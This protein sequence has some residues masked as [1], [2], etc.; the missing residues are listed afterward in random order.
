[1]QIAAMLRVKNEARWIGEVIDALKPACSPIFVMDDHSDDDTPRIC[2]A[3]GARVAASPYEGINE[4]RDKDWLLRGVE[5]EMKTGD[6]LLCIDGDEVLAPWSIPAV[7]AAANGSAPAYTFRIRYLWDSRDKVRVDGVYS[8]FRRPSMFRLRPGMSFKRTGAH[9]NLHCSSV[10]AEC[11]GEC[12]EADVDLLHLG[13]MD[14]ADRLR[15]YEWYNRIDPANSTEDGYR[16]M[17]IGDVFPADSTFRY[18]GPL[19]VRPL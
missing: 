19:E 15:K 7:I 1:M 5:Q 11:I 4:A 6:W 18:G 16:H 10:P 13:Y 14:R 2:A 8:S 9:A 12:A 17:V 3:H